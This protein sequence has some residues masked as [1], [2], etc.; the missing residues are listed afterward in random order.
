MEWVLSIGLLF[1]VNGQRLWMDAK[2]EKT[3]YATKDECMTA[4]KLYKTPQTRVLCRQQYAGTTMNLPPYWKP[5][6]V[7]VK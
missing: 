1:V 3:I 2:P 6:I 7:E 5:E 4:G